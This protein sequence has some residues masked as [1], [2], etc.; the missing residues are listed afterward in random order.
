MGP[1]A[2]LS[3]MGTRLQPTLGGTTSRI[4]SSMRIME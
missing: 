4:C 2:I 3:L 1:T